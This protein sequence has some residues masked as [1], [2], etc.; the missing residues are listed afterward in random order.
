[1]IWTTIWPICFA[2]LDNPVSSAVTWLPDSPAKRSLS[3]FDRRLSASWS[4]GSSS[5]SMRCLTVPP[6]NTRT[7]R[8]IQSRTLSSSRCL[9]SLS[10]GRG[11]VARAAFRVV[12]A[13]TAAA[14]RAHCSSSSRA[15]WNWWRIMRFSGSGSSVSP[16]KC[17]T[18]KRYPCSVG[19]RPA[20]VCGCVRKPSSSRAAISLR[21][22]AGLKPSPY[23]ET[24]AFDPTGRRVLD[25]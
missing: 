18:K 2:R 15:W 6:C 1:M 3:S 20:D 19:T 13:S 23:P 14:S 11:G 21:I 7:S 25:V 17:S 10:D 4:S 9:N 12:C 8:T 24:N 16:S 22:V 5:D